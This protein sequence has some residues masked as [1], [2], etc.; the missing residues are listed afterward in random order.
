MKEIDIFLTK[1]VKNEKTPSVQ[2]LL[3]NKDSLIHSFQ[4]GFANIRDEIPVNDNTTYH[5]FSVTKTFTALAIMQ[6]VQQQKL[7]LSDSVKNYI[8][9]FPYSSD[10]T[11]QQLL[12]HSAGIPNPM[13]LS[14]IHLISENETLDIEQFFENIVAQN[15]KAKS[16]PDEKFAYSNLGY[17]FLGQIIENVSG[18]KYEEFVNENIIQK[19]NLQSDELSFHINN[20]TQ[21]AKGYHKRWSLSNIILS[22]L[23]DKSKFFTNPEGKWDTFLNFYVNGV[24]YGGLIGTPKAFMIYIQELLKNDNNLIS[25]EYKDALFIENKINN[26]KL[27]GMC[28][29]WFKGNLNGNTYFAHAG[30]GGGYYCEIRL[31]PELGLGSVIFLNRSGMTDERILDKVDKYYFENNEQIE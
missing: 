30:G 22:F 23:I 18:L 1:Q 2:Y 25:D 21:H 28:K 10:I 7:N 16:K 8:P 14:W 6:L 17:I 3:F 15:K 12:A 4:H 11:I 20:E 9:D 5:A 31:Y 26:G 27:T 19:L 24:S 13:P 29:S